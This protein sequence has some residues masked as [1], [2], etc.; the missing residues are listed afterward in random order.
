MP[1]EILLCIIIYAE[2]SLYIY[3]FDILGKVKDLHSEDST[4][5]GSYRTVSSASSKLPALIVNSSFTKIFAF[6]PFIF[7]SFFSHHPF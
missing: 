2:D 4:V 6:W 7:F 3:V 1:Y 5:E